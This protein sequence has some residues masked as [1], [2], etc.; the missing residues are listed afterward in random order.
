MKRL[1]LFI[2]PMVS[3]FRLQAQ[4]IKE[5][6]IMELDSVIR[7]TSGPVVVNFWATWCAPCLEEIPYMQRLTAEKGV[8]FYLV[9]LDNRRNFDD[10]LKDF[11]KSRDFKAVHFWLNE[12]NADYFCPIVD[13]GWSGSIPASLFI[14]KEKQIRIFREEKIEEKDLEELLNSIQ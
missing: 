13:E 12:T 7:E 11:V 10:K 2:I 9:N 1:L 4:E 8:A 5:V 14:H 6:S 3:L